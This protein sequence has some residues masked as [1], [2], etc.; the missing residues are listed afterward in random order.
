MFPRSSVCARKLGEFFLRLSNFL[1]PAQIL[2]LY[3][4]DDGQE[5]F[6]KEYFTAGCHRT[7]YMSVNVALDGFTLLDRNGNDGALI[8]R[9]GADIFS[10]DFVRSAVGKLKKGDVILVE[11]LYSSK[12]SRRNWMFLSKNL[13]GV[14]MFDLYYC[15][16]VYV[17]PDRYLEHFK[18]NF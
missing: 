15:G 10:E 4:F 2:S 7:V 17:D 3:A 8:V 18:I 5:S 12:E 6:R 16:V 11:D 1:Q 14:L 9:C 13:K